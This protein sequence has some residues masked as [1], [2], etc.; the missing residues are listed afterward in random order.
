[1]LSK[2]YV[3]KCNVIKN[4]NYTEYNKPL[5]AAGFIQPSLCYSHKLLR[6][7]YFKKC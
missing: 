6:W 7:M 2:K 4:N 5:Q 1:M 3:Q